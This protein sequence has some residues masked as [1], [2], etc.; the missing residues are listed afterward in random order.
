MRFDIYR[1]ASGMA[2][3]VLVRQSELLMWYP[4]LR[5]DLGLFDLRYEASMSI[6]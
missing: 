3:I 1:G 4:S 2:S 6:F 5:S